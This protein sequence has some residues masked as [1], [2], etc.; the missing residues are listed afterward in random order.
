V[1]PL[2]PYAELLKLRLEE[3]DGTPLWVMPFHDD[4]VGRPGF[5]HGGAIA[6][7]LEVASFAA[8]QRALGEHVVEMKPITVTVDYMRAGNPVDTF[9]AGVV[10]RLG[11]RIANVEAYAWQ[12]ER[13]AP[14]AS[15]RL[16]FL[17]K[18]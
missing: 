3:R 14:I 10:E 13:S 4:V 16:N 8:L 6:G 12:T 11:S 2:P 15:A 18:R 17:L 5:L 9:A 7:L 1:T